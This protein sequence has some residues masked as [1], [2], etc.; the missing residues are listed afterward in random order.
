MQLIV[1]KVGTFAC[2]ADIRAL[3]R[4]RA[5]SSTVILESGIQYVITAGDVQMVMWSAN[6]LAL[7][8]PVS[9]PTVHARNAGANI[10]QSCLIEGASKRLCIQLSSDIH[11][12][13]SYIHLFN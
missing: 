4:Q 7:A 6:S 11:L 3:Q 8:K 2:T 1:Q 9:A 10:L 12:V 13:I 5:Q